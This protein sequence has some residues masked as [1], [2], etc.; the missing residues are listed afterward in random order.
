M[1]RSKNNFDCPVPRK[2]NNRIE[3]KNEKGIKRLSTDD[4]CP[5]PSKN[6]KIEYIIIESSDEEEEF[7]KRESSER[8]II[9]EEEKIMK[10]NPPSRE[11]GELS[12]DSNSSNNSNKDNNVKGS[13]YTFDD[14]SFD[15]KGGDIVE[16]AADDI[17]SDVEIIS[18]NSIP[19]FSDTI[20]NGKYSFD[21][22]RSVTDIRTGG[23]TYSDH[24]RLNY[25]DLAAT[26]KR[27][28]SMDLF[29]FEIERYYF[30]NRQNDYTLKQKNEITTKIEKVLQDVEQ[31]SSVHMTG[32]SV[33][34]LGAFNSDID[35]CWKSF[36]NHKHTA[37]KQHTRILLKK[38]LSQLRKK[39]LHHLNNITFINAV[40]P[41]IKIDLIY[42]DQKTQRD[43]RYDIDINYNN[44]P[45][46][47][48]SK[49]LHYYS[50]FD[51]RFPQLVLVLKH[52]AQI[53]EIKD[54]QNGYFN[55][56]SLA[57]LALHYL[58]C[59]VKPYVLPNLQKLYP[60][61]FDDTKTLV[62]FEYRQFF[63]SPVHRG[64]SRINKQPI[65]ELLV[66]FFHYYMNFDF[67]NNAISIREGKVIPR[68]KCQYDVRN[69]YCLFIEE[70]YDLRN[71]ARCITD[72]RNF[73][74]IRESFID[75]FDN[76]V[77]PLQGAIS[78]R[79]LGIG[80]DL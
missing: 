7:V 3:L 38:A 41:I 14:S 15:G 68:S 52:W 39:F 6:N 74:F 29:T 23:V 35:M 31:G 34:G 71:T 45:G 79:N 78:L 46:I 67:D 22:S 53:R 59:G 62:A 55:S 57:L 26:F 64:G 48:N 21:L 76:L 70:P 1:K 17:G 50:L 58:Q 2:K 28:G 37:N 44:C 20:T 12:T 4:E 77:Y 54:A 5:V 47:Y 51:R 75:A 63:E 9:V 80:I 43:V 66:G 72:V 36:G 13:S 10:S 40:V 69:E 25:D 73:D 24:A 60:H 61:I 11:E 33:T 30:I 42:P 16:I 32:S 65:S 56:Y 8:S 49:L 27:I 18:L 19:Q